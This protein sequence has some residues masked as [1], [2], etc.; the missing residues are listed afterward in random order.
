M[1]H[2]RREHTKMRKPSLQLAFSVTLSMALGACGGGGGGEPTTTTSTTADPTVTSTPPAAPTPVVVERKWADPVNMLGT[3]TSGDGPLLTP[4]GDHYAIA[5]WLSAGSGF[6]YQAALYDDT[7]NTWSTPI[8]FNNGTDV[9]ATSGGALHGATYPPSLQAAANTKGQVITAWNAFDG[10]YSN[11]WSAVL[12]PNTGLQ[13]RE[14]VENSDSGNAWA[15]EVSIN[16]NGSQAVVWVQDMGQPNG[17]RVFGRRREWNGAWTAP[18]RLDNGTE[19]VGI[20]EKPQVVID[21]FGTS[22]AL[23]TQPHNGKNRLLA[24]YNLGADDWSSAIGISDIGATASYPQVTLGS[25]RSVNVAWVESIGNPGN[26]RVVYRRYSPST[27]LWD[28]PIVIAS[29]TWPQFAA[30]PTITETSD[31]TILVSWVQS[32][33]NTVGYHDLY[34]AKKMS[35]TAFDA[36]FMLQNGGQFMIQPRLAAGANGA[37]MLTWSNQD[38]WYS[39]FSPATSWATPKH[40]DK[41]NNG[42]AITPV[43]FP[44][45]N[46]AAISLVNETVYV[47]GPPPPTPYKVVASVYRPV[48]Q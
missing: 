14:L 1:D 11:L 9:V 47:P 21:S 4:I 44:S 46:A 22:T 34:V 7:S 36:P 13:T 20:N 3:A 15:A 23:W 6:A 32:E 48:T 31:H 33:Y 18:T 25:D 5:T 10:A 17:W 41:L 19:Q 12:D 39:L 27:G 16:E 2:T 45:G 29:L 26:G 43:L 42:V 30:A 37:A 8:T 35:N 40:I 24:A 28:D 38:G